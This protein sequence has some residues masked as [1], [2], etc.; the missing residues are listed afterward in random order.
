MSAVWSGQQ[1]AEI[2]AHYP[3][4]HGQFGQGE[5]QRSVVMST[6]PAHLAAFRRREGMTRM[7]WVRSAQAAIGTAYRCT[8]SVVTTGRSAPSSTSES[9]E[10]G[11][12]R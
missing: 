7:V 11:A 6:V 5:A 3:L 8:V 4:A 9:G 1:G 12:R 2:F 10:A